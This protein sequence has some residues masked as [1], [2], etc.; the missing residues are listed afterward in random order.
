VPY[1]ALT[2]M[3]GFSVNACLATRLCYEIKLNSSHIPG[4]HVD[5]REFREPPLKDRR[6]SIG[7]PRTPTRPM[8][9]TLSGSA[10][11]T[12]CFA[13]QD[14]NGAPS[15]FLVLLPVEGASG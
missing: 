15:N 6:L 13:L 7:R 11:G 12:V 1:I 9:S 4:A 5:V 2:L 10:R 3:Q 8:N 14:E